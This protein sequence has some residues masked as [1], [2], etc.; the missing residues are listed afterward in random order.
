MKYIEGSLMLTKEAMAQHILELKKQRAKEFGL[1][2][3]Q[4]EQAVLEGKPLTPIQQPTTG[5][6][7][8]GGW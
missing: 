4:Y 3:E 5:S 7:F 8:G 2:L 6:S 1:T